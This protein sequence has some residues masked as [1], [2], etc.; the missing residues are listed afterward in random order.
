MRYRL[1]KAG[2]LAGVLLISGCSLFENGFD[3]DT[4]TGS[5]K[6]KYPVNINV[7]VK[8]NLLLNK[9]DIEV[10]LDNKNLGSVIHDGKDDFSLDLKEGS[11]ELVFRNK[12]D[13][14]IEAHETIT[15]N[16]GQNFKYVVECQTDQIKVLKKTV[17]DSENILL[18][19]DLS[20]LLYNDHEDS[21]NKLRKLGFEN[22]REKP[23]DTSLNFLYSDGETLK[24]TIDGADV[25]ETVC[26]DSD[27][28]V[29][30]YYFEKPQ[31]ESETDNESLFEEEIPDYEEESNEPEIDFSDYAGKYVSEAESELKSK[32]WKIIYTHAVSKLDFTEELPYEKTENPEQWKKW[33]ITEV[34]EIDE[35]QKE[36]ELFIIHTDHIPSDFEIPSSWE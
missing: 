17:C 25:D 20:E 18:N 1:M 8:G 26:Y 29:T 35:D 21:V 27:S 15:V 7:I 33:R 12:D 5:A 4:I 24:I 22:I 10:L 23:Q 19:S 31:K 30:V 14:S 16:S 28:D 34:G 9:Y 13:N 6:N 36:I 32:G 3:A 11:H 2:L